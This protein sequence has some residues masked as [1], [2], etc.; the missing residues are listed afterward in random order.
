M[1]I[2]E[3]VESVVS[4]EEIENETYKFFE[5][6]VKRNRLLDCI[7]EAMQVVEKEDIIPKRLTV[8]PD[9]FGLMRKY[10]RNELEFE[11]SAEKLK[12]G[13]MGV[14]YGAEIIILA[15]PS[16]GICKAE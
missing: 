6:M 7:S 4:K 3:R 9:V 5:V 11:T 14:I 15:G 2:I 13:I 1:N 8:S 12:K 16:S 10:L